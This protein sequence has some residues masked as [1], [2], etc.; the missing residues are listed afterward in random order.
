[1]PDSDKLDSIDEGKRQSL[2][3]FKSPDF[4]V[5]WFSGANEATHGYFMMAGT[6]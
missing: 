6:L 4:K 2:G 3:L 1:M 5:I